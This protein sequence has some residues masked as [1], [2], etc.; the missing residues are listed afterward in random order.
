MAESCSNFKAEQI[1]QNRTIPDGTEGLV[2]KVG[3]GLDSELEGEGEAGFVV[4]AN[5]ANGE[6]SITHNFFLNPRLCSSMR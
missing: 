3:L 2:G 5:K 6:N 4:G 1:K